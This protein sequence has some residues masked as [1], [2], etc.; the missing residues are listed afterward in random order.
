MS[1]HFIVEGYLQFN[2]GQK[3]GLRK[4]WLIVTAVRSRKNT[5]MCTVKHL[6]KHSSALGKGGRYENHVETTWKLHYQNGF[7]SQ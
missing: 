5:R 2:S 3:P 6:K 1:T 7:K 4:R